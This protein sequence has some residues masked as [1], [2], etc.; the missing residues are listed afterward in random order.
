MKPQTI[1]RRLAAIRRFLGYLG[2]HGD[3][4]ALQTAALLAVLWGTGARISEVLG[5]PVARIPPMS[6]AEGRRLARGEVV[7][8]LGKGGRRRRLVLSIE[9]R[10]AVEAWARAVPSDAPLFARSQQSVRKMLARLAKRAM[11]PHVHSGSLP[12]HCVQ[13]LLARRIGAESDEDH[14]LSGSPGGWRGRHG[15]SGCSLVRL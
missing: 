13:G 15:L 7:E 4:V 5:C 1:K 10:A 11:V 12:C 9:H 2:R 6:G 8:R 14:L 3:Q